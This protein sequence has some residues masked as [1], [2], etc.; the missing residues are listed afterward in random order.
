M[1]VK[2]AVLLP[3]EVWSAMRDQGPE[4][5]NRCMVGEPGGLDEYWANSKSTAWGQHIGYTQPDDMKH[6]IPVYW[7][8]NSANPVRCFCVISLSLSPPFDQGAI[9]PDRAH[10]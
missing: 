4:I 9:V 8:G 10:S 6:V 3:H 2:I 7:R 5:W 1:P